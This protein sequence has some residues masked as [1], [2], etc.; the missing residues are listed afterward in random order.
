[1]DHALQ[2]AESRWRVPIPASPLFMN[3]EIGRDG[4]LTILPPRSRPGDYIEL[5]AEAD[6]VVGFTA[7][8]AEVSNNYRLKPIDYEIRRQQHP[9]RIADDRPARGNPPM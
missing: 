4:A 5:R 8:S 2:G 9:A 1:M 6:L 3:V 7:C